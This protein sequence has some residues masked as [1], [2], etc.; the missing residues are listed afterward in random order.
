[1]AVVPSH[2]IEKDAKG[3][4]NTLYTHDLKLL[5]RLIIPPLQPLLSYLHTLRT[6]THSI[7]EKVRVLGNLSTMLNL[8]KG[9][10]I[11]FYALL[12]GSGTQEVRFERAP[13]G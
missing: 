4:R 2:T 1:M 5:Q 13:A 6:S 12:L 10:E 3:V 11:V 9:F 7:S 8:Q